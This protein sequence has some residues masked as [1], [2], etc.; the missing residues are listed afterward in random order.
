MLISPNSTIV[1]QGDSV[2][3]CARERNRDDRL[4]CGYAML[5]A[6]YL[7]MKYPE[8]NL[9]FFNRGISGDRTTNLMARW[10][11]DC[12][13]LNPDFVSILVG[14]NDTWRRYDSGVQTTTKEFEEN[15]RFLIE[16][17]QHKTNAKILLLEP[18]LLHYPFDR[19]QWRTDLDPKRAVVANLA[20]E[21]GT[22]FVSLDSIMRPLSDKYGPDY[23]AYDGV[24][25]TPAGHAV[26][27]QEW[28]RAVDALK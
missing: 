12:I 26:I 2:T 28:L 6:S 18:F 24:H 23:I 21:Y 15:Y 13:N 10:H 9:R 5:V 1:F 25:P 27:A 7:M 3:D 22:L 17:T 20:K 14:I 8:H 16:E 19:E 11:R 4:G